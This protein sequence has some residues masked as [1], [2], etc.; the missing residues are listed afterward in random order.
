M[1]YY[2]I[3]QSTSNL[4]RK[5]FADYWSSEPRSH[6]YVPPSALVLSEDPTTLFSS[7]GMQQLVPYLLGQ[8]HA[9]GKRLYNIQPCLRTTDIEEVGD[10][11][12]TT[13]FE[14]M[15]NWSL[16]DYFKSEQLSWVWEFFTKVL[17]LEK[18][19]LY[20]TVFE[21][22]KYAPAD[23]DCRK[24]WEKL[25][26]A[27]DHIFAYGSDKNWW[28]RSGT[29]QNM[30]EG[31]IGGPDSE[32]F[33][34]FEQVEHDKKYG[35]HCH[36]NCDCGRFIEIGNSVFIEYQKQG[37]EL[38]PMEQKNV[39]YGGGL[40]RIVAAMDNSSD[41][42]ATDLF[43]PIVK[44]VEQITA[45]EYDISVRSAMQVVVDHLKASVMLV[46]AGILPS[47][48]EHGYLLRRFLRRAAIKMRQL[49]GDFVADFSPVVNAVYNIYEDNYIKKISQ[50]KINS[51][52]NDELKRFSSTVETGLKM[53][54]KM[55][56]VDERAAFELYQSYGFPF[57]ITQEIVR[58]RGG[59]LDKAKFEEKLQSHKDLSRSKSAEKF[60]GGLA[61]HSQQVVRYHTA[62]HLLHQA[63][64]DVFGPQV[65]QEGSNITGERLRFDFYCQIK[66]EQNQIEQ[67]EKII[68]E[69]I[70]EAIP[71]NFKILDKKK[72]ES[73]GALSFFREKYADKVK[74]YYV[75]SDSTIENAYS[76]EFCGGPHVANTADIK[77]IKIQ[78]MKKIGANIYR[79]YA[80]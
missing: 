75:S 71:V 56:Q 73:L 11:R 33:Y 40:E 63:L 12:H 59:F 48:K 10:S 32:I 31:E 28:S 16:G 58:E 62:T 61:D 51:V 38:V 3:M 72:A 14:M 8:P 20:V 65:R 78:K 5:K 54:S 18:K 30:P 66:P 64:R 1:I 41:L 7:S 77:S 53:I 80:K 34:E 22:D 23:H 60:K 39:D 9:L 13:F 17:S 21:G 2:F 74:V 50:E 29:P 44:S 57:E 24:I 43:A 70:R 4:L 68:N 42:F 79:I 47:N 27:D 45:K 26:V 19:K 37:K 15:G 69:K 49:K 25:G 35:P 6:I 76:M 55:P 52:I 67:V 36:P 46:S